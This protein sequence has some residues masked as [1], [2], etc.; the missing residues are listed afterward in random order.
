VTKT[1][2]GCGILEHDELC[3]CDVVITDK[4]P[5][6]YLAIPHEYPNGEAIAYYGKWN[7]TIE[8]WFQIYEKA[9]TGLRQHYAELE[10]EMSIDKRKIEPPN[11]WNFKRRMPDEVYEYLVNGI[12]RGIKPTALRNELIQEFDYTI[13]RSYVTKLKDRLKAKGVL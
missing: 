4:T 1:P 9:T 5:D 10:A 12:R 11:G 2:E 6:S 13:D 3:L 7:G 8:H